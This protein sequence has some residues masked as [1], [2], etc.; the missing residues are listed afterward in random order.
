MESEFFRGVEGEAWISQSAERLTRL[1][2]RFL[3]M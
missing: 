1:E 3:R 2:A